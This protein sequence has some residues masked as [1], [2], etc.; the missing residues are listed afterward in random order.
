LNYGNTS[1]NPDVKTFTVSS[2]STFSSVTYTS[3][4]N[5]VST[6]YQNIPL[7]TSTGALLWIKNRTAAGSNILALSNTSYLESNTTAAAFTQDYVLQLASNGALIKNAST[8]DNWASWTFRK[9]PKFFDVVTYTGNGAAFGADIPH[10]LGSAPGFIAVKAVGTTS[11]W[12]A[13]HRNVGIQPLTGFGFNSSG[14]A[15]VTSGVQQSSTTFNTGSI[16]DRDLNKPTSNGVTYIAYLFAHNAGGF[17]ASSGDNVISCGRYTGNGSASGPVETLGYEPQWLMIKNATTTGDWLIIDNMRGM[18]VGSAAAILQANLADAESSTNYV[19][20]TATG[21]QVVSTSSQ[22]NTNGQLYIYIAIRRG[23]MKVPTTGTSVFAPS[24]RTGTGASGSSNALGAVT[25]LVITKSRGSTAA[26]WAWTDRLRGPTREVSSD[27]RNAEATFANDVTSFASM[28]GFA[29]GTGASGQVNTSSINYIDYL[30]RRSP[31]FMDIVC[32]SGTGTTMN[33]PHNLGAVPRLILIK[34]RNSSSYDWSVMPITAWTNFSNDFY[35]ELNSPGGLTTSFGIWGNANPT[36]TTFRV[37]GGYDAN[38]SGIN[39]VAYLFSDVPGVSKVGT[40]TGNGSSQTI[41]CGFA[42]R[43]I[44]IKDQGSGLTDWY[45]WDS[46]RGINASGVND[47]YLV[48]NV[49]YGGEVTTNDSVYADASGFGV[50]Q[51]STTAVNGST[52]T[53][54]YLAIA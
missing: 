19:S 26:S 20:P 14:G 15:V 10:N 50:I 25:D 22:V 44:L 8:T 4:A 39:Y 32:Y 42:A 23:P 49:S 45:V 7:S 35:L 2:G 29:F 31:G 27:S 6:V 40:Y 38:Q 37:G 52:R 54:I 9:Q 33:V 48:F 1:T 18:P 21:F 16:Q 51:N 12:F 47:P 13:W 28:T 36:A 53:Y 11:A 5:S 30:F 46:A 41:N 43:F 34:P 17:G 3:S 24:T